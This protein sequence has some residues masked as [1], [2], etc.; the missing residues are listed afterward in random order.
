[1]FNVG[2]INGS[3]S[4]D[5]LTMLNHFGAPEGVTIDLGDGSDIL[6]L[7]NPSVGAMLTVANVE[8]V[9]GTQFGDNIILATGSTVT[10]GVGVDFIT[11]S[12][13]ADTFRF[14]AAFESTTAGNRDHITG[15]DAM[16]DTFVFTGV[17]FATNVNFVGT[18]AF[19]GGGETSAR[20]DG[21]I[22][23]IDGDGDGQMTGLLDMEIELD[24]LNGPLTNAD[25]V[26]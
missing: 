21:A 4:D 22:L 17:G 24:G 9:N 6:H 19:A 14:T 18:G 10:G 26:I 15:F 11:A 16:E 2:T 13:D 7:T 1:V 20:M 23:Q 12:N 25:F 8:T 5:T 3:A